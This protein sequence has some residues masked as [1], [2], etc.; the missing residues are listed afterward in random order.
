MEYKDIITA[1]YKIDY[2]GL[3]L[4]SFLAAYLFGVLNFF[5]KNLLLLFLPLLFV[6]GGFIYWERGEYGLGVGYYV[7]SISILLGTAIGGF[8]GL[9]FYPKKNEDK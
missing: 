4:S 3:I 1:L 5:L 8:L 6:Y 9:Y 7:G 2:K